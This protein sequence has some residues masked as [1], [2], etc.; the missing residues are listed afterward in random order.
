MIL[1]FNIRLTLMW[2]V[3]LNELLRL[4]HKTMEEN[5]KIW[6]QRLTRD[7]QKTTHTS[8]WRTFLST[9]ISF[10]N[11]VL[12]A[13]DLMP[14]NTQLLFGTFIPSDHIQYIIMGPIYNPSHISFAYFGLVW[15]VRLLFYN[16]F[17]ILMLILCRHPILYFA[18]DNKTKCSIR[19][20]HTSEYIR[21]I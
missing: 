10:R 5:F 13:T 2:T 3:N 20:Q 6:L 17:Y 11:H 16:D 18:L 15:C 14:N 12:N 8:D 4:S 21:C 9:R 1:I 19:A 7:W